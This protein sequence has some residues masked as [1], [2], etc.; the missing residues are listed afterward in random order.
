MSRKCS[1]P[2]HRRRRRRSSAFSASSTWPDA[3]SGP[4]VR[5]HRPQE[6]LFHLLRF[7]FLALRSCRTSD[8]GQSGVVRPLLRRH[9][10]H[11]RGGLL[12][13]R[14]SSRHVRHT[15]R[16]RDPRT[17]ITAWSVAGVLGPVL[18]N[19]IRQYQDRRRRAKAKPITSRC[20]LWRA[21]GRRLHRQFL[22]KA[23]DD[24]HHMDLETV[25][26]MVGVA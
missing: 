19:Y 14:L 5:L 21:L 15:L 4:D 7:G 1:R 25:D 3:S 8:H 26:D 6:H 12:P 2:R 23:V 22:I 11:V 20:T 9:L 16:R 10:K 24:R 13:C 17:S 18:V